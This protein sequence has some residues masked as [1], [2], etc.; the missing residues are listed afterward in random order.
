MKRWSIGWQIPNAPANRRFLFAPGML[1]SAD[2][3]VGSP[4]EVMTVSKDALVLGG[5]QTAVVVAGKTDQSDELVARRI[6]VQVGSAYGSDV[7]I[8]GNVNE[9]ELVVV[10]GNERLRTGESLKII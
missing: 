9:G 6:D 8:I 7:E 10:E 4:I 3:A 5:D 1:A 2:L